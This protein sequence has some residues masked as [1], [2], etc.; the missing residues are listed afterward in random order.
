MKLTKSQLKQ[1]IKEELEAVLSE[2]KK[3]KK[4]K[5]KEEKGL[6]WQSNRS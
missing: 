4:K 1:I 6:D 3:K 2:K 5:K